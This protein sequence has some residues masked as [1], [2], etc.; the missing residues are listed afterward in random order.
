MEMEFWRSFAVKSRKKDGSYKK[1]RRQ[2]EL[3]SFKDAYPR[4]Y[5]CAHGNELV[6][7][8]RI[9]HLH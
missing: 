4:A 1:M 2:R 3:F 8:T 9:R 6:K 5:V 7:V